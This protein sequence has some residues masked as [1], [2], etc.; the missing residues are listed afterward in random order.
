VLLGAIG[1]VVNYPFF[2]IQFPTEIYE[3]L[4]TAEKKYFVLVM[5]FII[6]FELQFKMIENH[7]CRVYNHKKK[8]EKKIR[9]RNN[10]T[11]VART[12]KNQNKNNKLKTVRHGCTHGGRR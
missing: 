3:Y 6:E 4:G 2:P 1:T 11:S 8:K 9:E 7:I 12:D 5:Y 10:E